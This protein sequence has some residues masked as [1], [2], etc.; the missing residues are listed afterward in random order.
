MMGKMDEKQMQQAMPDD[1]WRTPGFRR[2]VMSQIEEAVRQ[3]GN[4]TTKTSMEMENHVFLK[5]KSREDYLGL[6]ARLI[7]HVREINSKK[8]KAGQVQAPVMGQQQMQDPINAL[9]NLAKQNLSPGIPPQQQAPGMPGQMPSQQLRAQ[10]HPMQQQMMHQQRQGM[11]QV[12][13]QMQGQRPDTYLLQ[14]QQQG[15]NQMAMGMHQMPPGMQEQYG[16]YVTYQYYPSHSHHQYSRNSGQLQRQT[17]YPGPQG[18]NQQ[19]PHHAMHDMHHLGPCATPPSLTPTTPTKE[20]PPPPYLV[21]E[22]PNQQPMPVSIQQQPSPAPP[23]SY[24]VQSPATMLASPSP[25]SQV[26]PSPA[27]RTMGA[28]SPGQVQLHTPGNVATQ[29][30]VPSPA[31]RTPEDQAYL[32]K[33]QQLSKFKEPLKAFIQSLDKGDDRHKKEKIKM[34]NLLDVLSNPNKRLSMA[35]LVRCE[36]IL[37]K[38]DLQVKATLPSGITPS[39]TSQVSQERHMCQPLLD[40]IAAHMKSPLLNHTLQRTFGPA[41]YAI[42]GGPPLRSHSPPAKRQ[43]AE[44]EKDNEI[45]DVLQGEL[46]RLEQR[47]KVTLDPVHHSGSK[48]VHLVFKLDDRNLPS[49]PPIMVT[50]PEDYPQSSPKCETGDENYD[51]TPFLQALYKALKARLDR[52]PDKYS[53]TALLNTW[54]M[55]VRQACASASA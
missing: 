21:R 47:F 14:Q 43:K 39:T 18:Y 42:Q 25:Q 35:A 16:S 50:V 32:E 45:A 33:L 23:T 17:S 55:S 22:H 46:A 53:V 4:P 30:A 44:P 24:H 2:K 37:E 36:Q 27:S 34:T 41:L 29:G 1:M 8:E 10:L 28:P 12:L 20:Y 6:V 5:A 49:V 51:S 38:L 11:P 31:S 54:E 40:T 9:Q 3:A 48:T 15:M 52:M 13:P 26:V 19:P 7:I